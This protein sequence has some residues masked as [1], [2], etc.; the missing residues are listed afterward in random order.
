MG[1]IGVASHHDQAI[2]RFVIGT[3]RPRHQGGTHPIKKVFAPWLD[4]VGP[5]VSF[6]QFQKPC[7]WILKKKELGME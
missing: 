5:A 3:D 6:E 7:R 4:D 1:R 2:A